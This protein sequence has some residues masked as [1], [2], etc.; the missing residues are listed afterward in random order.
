[1]DNNQTPEGAST[2]TPEALFRLSVAEL[3]D[4][5]PRKVSRKRSPALRPMSDKLRA[6]NMSDKNRAQLLANIETAKA[7]RGGKMP[8]RHGVPDGWKGPQRRR[9]LA[10][11]R[12]R[13][14]RRADDLLD[15][16]V[17]QGAIELPKRHTPLIGPD[18]KMNEDMAAR[19]ALQV[20]IGLLLAREDDTG[21]YAYTLRD[22]LWA[23]RLVLTY[24]K[25]QPEHKAQMG[26]SAVERAE[27]F[28]AW[29]AACQ[30]PEGETNKTDD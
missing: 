24:T 5:A 22:R 15:A 25:A 29:L 7:K 20:A 3:R 14:A 17:A 28:L 21:R 8:S 2:P 12:E 9:K 16:L 23:S 1:M 10:V 26:G 18:G 6:W 11:I 4:R 19:L 30:E 13:S 27:S